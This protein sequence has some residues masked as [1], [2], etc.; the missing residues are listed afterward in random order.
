MHSRKNALGR[1]RAGRKGEGRG[2]ERQGQSQTDAR[3]GP[4]VEREPRFRG[5][6]ILSGESLVRLEFWSSTGIWLYP[7]PGEC[8]QTGGWR[9]ANREGKVMQILADSKRRALCDSFVQ[10]LSQVL[11]RTSFRQSVL[12]MRPTYVWISRALLLFGLGACSD[13]SMAASTGVV[14]VAKLPPAAARPVD[15]AKDIRPIFEKSCQFCHGAEKQKG[16]YRLDSK[17]AA[18]KGGETYSPAIQPSDSAASPLIHLVAGLVLDSKMPAKGDP[19]TPEQIGLLRAWID[20][21]AAWPED[22]RVEVDPIKSHWAFQ[23]VKRPA[24]PSLLNRKSEIVN[25][26]DAFIAAKL[27]ESKLTTSRA[28]DGVTLIRRLYFVMLGLPPTPE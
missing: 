10:R 2:T 12:V 22:G 18:I 1:F 13:V 28:A 8:P 4:T 16:G 19:L 24:V 6:K 17:F 3:L 9:R 26:I 27:V 11:R 14:D 25:P 15:F 23:P 20:Q 5:P 21:G 7:I